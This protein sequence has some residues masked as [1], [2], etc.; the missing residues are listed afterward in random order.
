VASPLA[1]G[2]PGGPAGLTHPATGEHQ[3]ANLGALQLAG[4]P[5]GG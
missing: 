1:L 3:A 2:H 5:G 4:L